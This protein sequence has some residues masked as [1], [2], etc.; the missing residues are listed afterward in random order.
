MS[1]CLRNLIQWSSHYL[2]QAR[3]VNR[4]FWYACIPPPSPSLSSR[5]PQRTGDINLT[6]HNNTNSY[7]ELRSRRTEAQ[8]EVPQQGFQTKFA[9]SKIVM[10][11]PKYLEVKQVIYTPPL[12]R[13]STEENSPF[14]HPF[15]IASV[16]D[17]QQVERIHQYPGTPRGG[18]P[19]CPHFMCL[20]SK[21]T[22]P[23]HALHCLSNKC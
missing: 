6:R 1:S 13:D 2:T 23:I 18:G 8:T 10:S 7:Q 5:P 14:P 12:S 17:S 4:A 16:Q 11:P 15:S 3:V 21:H 9:P 22:S 20:I 19:T